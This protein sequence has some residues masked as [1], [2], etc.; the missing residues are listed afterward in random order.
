[1]TH[2]F[3]TRRSADHKINDVLE[4]SSLTYKHTDVLESIKD[5]Q[6]E[7]SK[8]ASVD[9]KEKELLHELLIAKQEHYK[10][11][12]DEKV[13]KKFFFFGI[14]RSEEHTSELQSLMRISYAVLCLNKKIK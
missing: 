10:K 11:I 7:L 3:P 5:I 13:V 1:M 14:Y 9:A 6:T 2:S 12:H 8:L 4:K